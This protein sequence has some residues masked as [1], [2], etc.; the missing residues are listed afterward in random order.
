MGF[1]FLLCAVC[2]GTTT[3]SFSENA[4]TITLS[5][6]TEGASVSAVSFNVLLFDSAAG[7]TV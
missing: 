7:S 6:I 4:E 2:A 5:S 3:V 1:K